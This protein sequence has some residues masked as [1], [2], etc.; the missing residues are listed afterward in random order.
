MRDN[1]ST[2]KATV[3]WLYLRDRCLE[4][5]NIHG[6]LDVRGWGG[7]KQNDAIKIGLTESYIYG[8]TS[9]EEGQHKERKLDNKYI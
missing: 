6:L 2:G 7:T 3:I 5:G 1:V 9:L 4:E 8:K